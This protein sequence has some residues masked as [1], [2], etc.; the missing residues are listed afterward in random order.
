MKDDADFVELPALFSQQYERSVG[1]AEMAEAIR[2]GRTPRAGGDQ[3]MAVL[4]L[5]LGFLDSSAWGK[6]YEPVVK[7]ERPAALPGD[8]SLG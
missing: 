1:L 3:A 7:Y 2:K 4:D 6:A 5:M 8:G